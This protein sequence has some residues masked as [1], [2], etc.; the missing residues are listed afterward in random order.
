[1]ENHEVDLD[2]VVICI[3]QYSDFHGDVWFK[4]R[5]SLNPQ[6]MMP[7]VLVTPHT[8][9]K[10]CIKTF[11]MVFDTVIKK[12]EYYKI[13]TF[14]EACDPKNFTTINSLV[15]SGDID[16]IKLAFYLLYNIIHEK[17]KK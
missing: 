6:Y 8:N 3:L 14:G 12:Y 15:K 1:M 4:V 2:E 13:F 16:N 9:V 5:E 10:N 11:I 7:G 17:S